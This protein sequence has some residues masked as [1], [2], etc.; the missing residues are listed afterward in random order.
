MFE[1]EDLFD[2]TLEGAFSNKEEFLQFASNASDEDLYSVLQEGAFTDI[3]E[4]VSLKKKRRNRGFGFS[5]RGSYYYCGFRNSPN[6]SAFG[7]FRFPNK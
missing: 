7:I 6:A 3:N 5:Y 2:L 1:I 4:F